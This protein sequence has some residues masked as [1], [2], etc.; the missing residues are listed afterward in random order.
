MIKAKSG[1][2]SYGTSGASTPHHL[3]MEM[4]LKMIDAK[5][6]HVPYRGSGPALTDVV[7]GQI[8]MMMV[9]LAV[10]MP[11]IREGKVIAYGVTSPKRIQAMPD[12]PTIAEAGLPGFAATGWFSVVAAA[13]TPR[14]IIDKMNG[15]LD[16]VSDGGPEV[17]E[18]MRGSPSSRSTRRR[19]SWKSHIAT[20]IEEMG[21][22]GQG[23]GDYAGMS[24]GIHVSQPTTR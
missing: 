19:T 6:Q 17:R 20:E 22:G 8:P 21:A 23:R 15:I 18:K 1:Q 5:A 14:P 9:D 7:G 2:M 13:G 12:M 4:F 3:F 24:F 11:M 10:A 16:G